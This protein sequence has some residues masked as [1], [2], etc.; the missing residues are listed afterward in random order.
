VVSFRFHLVSLVGVFLA[1]GLGVLIGT[2]VINRGI[3]TQLERQTDQLTEDAE[4]LRGDVDR[5]EGEVEAWSGYGEETMDYVLSGRLE[6]QRVV[7]ITQDGTDDAS[8]DGVLRALR[9]AL[10]EDDDLVLVGPLSVTSR[11]ALRSE[12]DRTDLAA[13]LGADPASEPEVLQ[14]QAADRL[15]QRLAFGAPGDDTLEGL[16]TEG[17][18]VDE[19]PELGEAS[20]RGLGGDGELVVTIAGGP[21][22][23]MLRPEGFLLPLVADLATD[24]ASVAAAEPANGQEDEPPFVALLRSDGEVSGRIATQDNIDQVAGQ[25]GIVLALEDLVRGVAGHYGV[26]DGA[27]APLPEV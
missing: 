8:I 12:V 18:L 10:G 14:A 16:L 3:V 23:S 4:R 20:L 6:G 19:G 7:L 11:M 15:A 21:A 9:M 2:T 5:L 26:K 27:D 24:G 25:V 13:I 1:L 22:T 17:F